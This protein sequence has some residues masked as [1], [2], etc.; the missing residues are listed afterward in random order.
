MRAMST[1]NFSVDSINSTVVGV[2]LMPAHTAKVKMPE[3]ASMVEY[4]NRMREWLKEKKRKQAL[5]YAN[6]I[7][8]HHK[9][10]DILSGK[11]E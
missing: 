11:E 9:C 8:R 7:V 2:A 10:G 4:E 3:K 5:Y 6:P 1:V